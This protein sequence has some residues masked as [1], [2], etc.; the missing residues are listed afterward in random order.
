M[1]LASCTSQNFGMAGV[2]IQQDI[3][4]VDKSAPKI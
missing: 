4:A 3:M 1:E 2:G